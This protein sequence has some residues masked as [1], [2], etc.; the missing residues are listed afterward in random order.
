MSEISEGVNVPSAM[1]GGAVKEGA[2]LE[3]T[4]AIGFL[5]FGRDT[6]QLWFNI[7]VGHQD[8]GKHER[9]HLSDA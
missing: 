8:P 2:A 3:G 9:S 6:G 4:I 1:Q 5:G 7:L